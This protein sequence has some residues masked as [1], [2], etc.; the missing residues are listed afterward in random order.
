MAK[1]LTAVA[2]VASVVS[3][4]RGHVLEPVKAAGITQNV[5]I[6]MIDPSPRLRFEPPQYTP[7]GVS[8]TPPPAPRIQGLSVSG[9]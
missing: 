3:V 2:L 7:V 5:P 9:V 1:I 8:V 4:A 6:T